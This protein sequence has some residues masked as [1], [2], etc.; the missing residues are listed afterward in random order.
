MCATW[1]KFEGAEIMDL[2]IPPF[3]PFLLEDFLEEEGLEEEVEEEVENLAAYLCLRESF[4]KS[5]EA[6]D[7]EEK[8]RPIMQSCATTTIRW[9]QYR[10][11][12]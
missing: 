1:L 8:A 3:F 5:S 9:Y 7:S 6:S 4:L 2:S 12:L 11:S 10:S